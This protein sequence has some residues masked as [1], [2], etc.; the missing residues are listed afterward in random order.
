MGFHTISHNVVTRHVAPSRSGFP[1]PRFPPTNDGITPVV[2]GD[3]RNL[4]SGPA[5][6]AIVKGDGGVLDLHGNLSLGGDPFPRP[7]F[8]Y[9]RTRIGVHR[10]FSQ[11]KEGSEKII[12]TKSIF[13]SNDQMIKG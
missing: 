5:A 8:K 1:T 11:D 12:T 7:W 13:I 9:I 4:L 10:K 6:V 3:D 2:E